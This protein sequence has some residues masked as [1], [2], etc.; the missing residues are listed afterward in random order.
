[1]HVAARLVEGFGAAIVGGHVVAPRVHEAALGA[2]DSAEQFTAVV[3]TAAT[4]IDVEPLHGEA[5]GTRCQA[6]GQQITGLCGEEGVGEQ[7][8]GVQRA[9]REGRLA[10]LQRFGAHPLGFE[11]G[12]ERIGHFK[13]ADHVGGIAGVA[14]L[15]DAGFTQGG[16]QAA[17][18]VARTGGP[19]ILL[20]HVADKIAAGLEHEHVAELRRRDPVLAEHARAVQRGP[21]TGGNALANGGEG[22]TGGNAD[23][24]D[25]TGEHVVD[26]AVT[27]R[28]FGGGLA[29]G[30]K[31]AGDRR[32]LHQLEHAAAGFRASFRAIGKE[33]RVALVIFQRQGDVAAAIGEILA[34]GDG[35]QI[36]VGIATRRGAGLNPGGEAF[37]IALQH[38]VDDA[39]DGIGTIDRRVAAGDDVHALD[40]VNRDGRHVNRVGARLRRHMAQAVLQHQRAGGALATQIEDGQTGGA[41]EAARVLAGEGG[42]ELRQQCDAVT[43]VDLAILQQFSCAQRGDRH[44]GIDVLAR[45]ARTGHDHHLGGGLFGGPFGSGGLGGLVFG[46]KRRRR[47]KG[48]G[49]CPGKNI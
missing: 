17:N 7:E 27:R 9:G 19:E 20:H 28:A 44:R 6:G 46:S 8:G 15:H 42:A 13:A 14:D 23:V 3:L 12:P 1:M 11:I 26:D 45:D 40:Q 29:I 30:T 38:E 5:G 2:D 10:F 31:R 32:V 43:H 33:Q 37:E 25:A 34:G 16:A 41:D 36:L 48:Q 35:G 22:A 39:G 47:G 18:A 24:L 21:R 49:G 4:E